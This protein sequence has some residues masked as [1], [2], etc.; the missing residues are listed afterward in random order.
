M[1]QTSF[2]ETNNGEAADTLPPHARPIVQPDVCIGCKY[3]NLMQFTNQETD[4]GTCKVGEQYFEC[5]W[6][7]IIVEEVAVACHERSEYV[8]P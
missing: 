4:W 1:D 8:S 3:L 7:S 5:E 2:D 6:P